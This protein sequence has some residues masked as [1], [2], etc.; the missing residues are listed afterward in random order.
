MQSSS[1]CVATNELGANVSSRY[2]NVANG[3]VVLCFWFFSL[4][5]AILAIGHNCYL[6]L[7]FIALCAQEWEKL[8]NTV[9]GKVKI[10]YWDLDQQGKLPSTLGEVLGTPTLRLYRPKPRDSHKQ[11]AASN[12]EKYVVDFNSRAR[13]LKNMYDFVESQMPSFVEVVPF[14]EQYPRKVQLKAGRYGL[15]HVVLFTKSEKIK[16]TPTFKYLSTEFRWKLVVVQVPNTKKNEDLRKEFGL[17]AEDLP[18][19]FVVKGGGGGGTAAP[20]DGQP[21]R[22]RYQGTDFTTPEFKGFLEEYASKEEVYD[23]I[24]LPAVEAEL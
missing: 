8:A 3:F 21:E 10:A 15:N 14:S 24:E 17:R 23:P 11:T 6:L 16:I 18:A 9:K 4:C 13:L 20:D 19:L 22:I 7:L 5:F 1:T 12:A 2:V